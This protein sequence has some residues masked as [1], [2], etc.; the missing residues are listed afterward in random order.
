MDPK[1]QFNLPKNVGNT[2]S[3]QTKVKQRQQSFQ[4]PPVN[5][6][7]KQVFKS[8]E[9]SEIEEKDVDMV[10]GI[11]LP[12]KYQKEPG[13]SDETLIDTISNLPIRQLT[14]DDSKPVKAKPE[15]LENGRHLDLTLNRANGIGALYISANPNVTS[16]SPKVLKNGIKL[17]TDDSK[18]NTAVYE[19]ALGPNI[20]KSSERISLLNHTYKNFEELL[21]RRAYKH[22]LAFDE[23]P[24]IGIS[25]S[26]LKNRK[27][28]DLRST[29]SDLIES[30][31][32]FI[33]SKLNDDEKCNDPYLFNYEETLNIL[34]LLTA[35]KFSKNDEHII[36]LQMWVNRADIKPDDELIARIKNVDS[37][38]L[39]ADVEFWASYIKTLVFRG[40]F[41]E[42]MEAIEN[43]GFEQYKEDD[44]LLYE[45][46]SKLK[47]AL[48]NYDTMSFSKDLDQFL[49]WKQSMAA[50]KDDCFSAN[51]KN[52][53]VASAIIDIICSMSGENDNLQGNCNNWFE[54]LLASFMFVLPSLQKL[55]DYMEDAQKLFPITKANT[56]EQ[57]CTDIIYGKYLNVLSA[58]ET[59][60]RS[61]ATYV[62]IMLSASGLLDSYKE[63]D[64]GQSKSKSVVS[65]IDGMIRQLALEYLTT[66]EF[67]AIGTGILII[68]DDS[69]ARQILTQMLPT[70]QI[71]S[72][73]DFEWCLSICAKLRL[74]GTATEIYDI[75]GENLLNAGFE[76]ESLCCFAEADNPAKVVDTVWKIFENLLVDGGYS[77]DLLNEK[78]DSGDFTSPIL[79]Q[80]LA[81]VAIL[82]QVLKS[83]EGKLPFDKVA[84]LL[85]F[86]YLPPYYKIIILLMLI[87]YF[88]TDTFNLDDLMEI[89][90]ILNIYE[91][92]LQT[93]PNCKEYSQQMLDMALEQTRNVQHD[94]SGTFDWRNK[95]DLPDSCEKLI[96]EMRKLLSFEIS[97]KFLE[98]SSST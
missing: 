34:N 19:F 69:K 48:A 56:W 93:V 31:T 49:L 44:P 79:L 83:E 7:S 16:S 20:D 91:K 80:S 82:R 18:V 6:N 86:R 74:P 5:S 71:K 13:I 68:T 77:D 61:V 41:N 97:F 90:K 75:Q 88:N 81:P 73:D 84:E 92:Q 10:K 36:L 45:M 11:Q 87:P 24:A 33:D 72:G 15:W 28:D 67:F 65:M 66:Y 94:D 95:K 37:S 25:D 29:I 22:F 62:A 12:I 27:K 21:R 78:I 63:I 4:F 40:Y 23:E 51:F 39:H 96:L 98:E 76:Y 55:P 8:N 38:T 85:E 52:N 57:T 50:L 53:E 14:V 35:I 70:Y 26:A 60:D 17:L 54:Y 59:L 2:F 64:D 46:I 43:S 47:D 1:F 89:I 30:Y 9:K 3:E 32:K 58:L 42:A